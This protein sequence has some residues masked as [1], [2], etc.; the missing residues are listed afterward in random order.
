[1]SGVTTLLDLTLSSQGSMEMLVLVTV[2]SS[3][4]FDF[5]TER[6][7]LL[8]LAEDTVKKN[9]PSPNIHPLL[10]NLSPLGAV[11]KSCNGSQ[12]G[13]RAASR[14]LIFFAAF[15]DN[16]DS[17]VTTD[18]FPF[19]LT[20]LL[21]PK[22]LASWMEHYI[23]HVIFVSSA[24]HVSGTGVNFSTLGDPILEAYEP[25]TAYYEAKFANVLSAFKLSKCS[26]G[27][28]NAYNVDLGVTYTNIMLIQQL[29][30]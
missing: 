29:W 28:I 21:A 4:G 8:R 11:R 17:Q 9:F 5:E 27:Q 26:K 10:L 30:L 24:A 19:L 16:L 20:T 18:H 7:L 3:N 14:T 13:P 6:I 23:P 25:R 15:Q 2:R 12:R 1:M 22:I